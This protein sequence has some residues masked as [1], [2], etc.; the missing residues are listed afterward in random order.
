MS[1]KRENPYYD[2]PAHQMRPMAREWSPA[3]RLGMAQKTA[4]RDRAVKVTLKPMPWSGPLK[5]R[6]T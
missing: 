3:E 6:T 1:Y 4:L 5:G 2:R